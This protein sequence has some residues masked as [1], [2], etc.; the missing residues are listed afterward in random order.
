MN[1]KKTLIPILASHTASVVLIFIFTYTAFS[2][3]L[4]HHLF[5]AQLQHFPWLG[6]VSG[7]ISWVIPA[8]ELAVVML[9]LFPATRFS[10]LCASLLILLVFTSYL[11]VM[12]ST[13]ENLPCSCGGII[14]L[15]N[16]KQH[17][18]LNIFLM[19]LSAMAISIEK[20]RIEISSDPLI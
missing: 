12:I 4:N 9:L 7:I 17:I 16:W 11:I 6:N 1:Q 3:L 19:M 20:F 13:Q 18:L 10:G 15:L 8:A 14:E 2:K 5:L